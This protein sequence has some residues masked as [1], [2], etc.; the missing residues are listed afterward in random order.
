MSV[1]HSVVSR[2]NGAYTHD[3]VFML[4]AGFVQHINLMFYEQDCYQGR[5]SEQRKIQHEI[6]NQAR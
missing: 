1:I 4:D 6:D 3:E 5:I 2:S